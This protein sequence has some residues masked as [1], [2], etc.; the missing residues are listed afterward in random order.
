MTQ[1]S[2]G[3]TMKRFLATAVTAAVL[4]TGGVAVAGATSG[5]D[6]GSSSTSSTVSST[7]SSTPRAQRQARHHA[8]L[9]AARLAIATAAKAIGVKPKDLV[10]AIRQGQTIA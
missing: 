2:G 3:S 4:A 10:A 9:R 1:A 7:V 5:S 8:R 6:G